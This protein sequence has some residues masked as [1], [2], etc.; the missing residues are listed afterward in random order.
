VRRAGRETQGIVPWYK[1]IRPSW[2]AGIIALIAIIAGIVAFLSSSQRYATPQNTLAKQAASADMPAASIQIEPAS[3]TPAAETR[4]PEAIAQQPEIRPEMNAAAQSS[5]LADILSNPSLGGESGASFTNL[6]ACWGTDISMGPSD[7]GC[8]VGNAHGFECLFQAGG[9]ARLR[10]LDLP[11]ILEVSLPDGQQH[12][13][14]LI[15]LSDDTAQLAIGSQKYAFPLSELDKVWDGS[16]ILLWK[17]P[18]VFRRLYPG[19][20]GEDV[21]WVRN[22]LD[23]L[24]GNTLGSQAPDYFD[25]DLQQRVE[26][27]QQA[28]SLA[29]DGVIGIE[30]IVRLVRAVGESKSPS[31]VQ[32]TARGE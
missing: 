18:F 22:A 14:T 12:L 17:P 8:K 20:K 6:F 26:R 16:F 9:W 25:E 3:A 24:E 31:I 15:G 2:A 19:I 29:S 32:H 13:V 30:T 7:L 28:Q 11:A 5:T 23:K 21:A 10:R 27:F 4:K 1:R